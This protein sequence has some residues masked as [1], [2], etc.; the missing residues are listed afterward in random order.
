[1]R[2]AM[3]FLMKRDFHPG[4]PPLGGTLTGEV[5]NQLEFNNFEY[6]IPPLL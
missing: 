6:V 1:M 4:F 5:H 2:M 3:A